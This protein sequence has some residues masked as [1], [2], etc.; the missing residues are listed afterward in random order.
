MAIKKIIVKGTPLRDEGVASAAVTPGHL[1]KSVAAGVAVHSVAGGN[2]QG[3]IAVEREMTGDDIDTA[4]AANDQI[5]LAWPR[6]GDVF[7]GLVAAAAPA[8]IK[9]DPLEAAADGTVRKHTPQAVDE[10]GT[11]TYTIY[12]DAIVGYAEE[13]VDNSGGGSA[14]RILVRRA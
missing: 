7:N 5:L 14:V 13:A 2:W 3:A 6:A 8:I 10:G 12:A 9:G 11:A 4:Y 1:V